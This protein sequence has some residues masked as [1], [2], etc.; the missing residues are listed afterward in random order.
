MHPPM[1]I[2]ALVHLGLSREEIRMLISIIATA[3]IATAA[4]ATATI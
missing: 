4:I 1:Y 3:T 2:E